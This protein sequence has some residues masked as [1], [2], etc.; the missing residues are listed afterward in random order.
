[1]YVCMYVCIYVCIYMH[2]NKYF[3]NTISLGINVNLKPLKQLQCY[4]FNL[5]LA[6]VTT[7]KRMCRIDVLYLMCP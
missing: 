1:M 5:L 2:A 7:V 3:M 4:S 6:A